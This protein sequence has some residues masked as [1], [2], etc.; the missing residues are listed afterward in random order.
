M[1]YGCWHWVKWW[2]RVTFVLIALVLLG[3]LAGVR[4]AESK[5][6][7]SW[8]DNAAIGALGAILL[9]MPLG[10]IAGLVALIADWWKR[11]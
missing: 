11:E 8:A 1:R 7:L 5:K 9:G 6:E 4:Y 10:L 2:L 3:S